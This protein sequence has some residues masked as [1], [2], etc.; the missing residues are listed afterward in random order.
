MLDPDRPYAYIAER[1]PLLGTQLGMQRDVSQKASSVGVSTIFLTASRCG[2]GCSMCDLHRNTLPTATPLGAI[3]RQIRFAQ[4]QLPAADWVKLYNSG[5]F[6]DRSSIPVADYRSIGELCG[7]YERVIIENH[8][9]F[10]RNRHVEFR[11]LIQGRLEIAVGLE[12]VQPRMLE[13]LGKQMTRDDFDRYAFFLRK[14][15]IDLRVFL[16]FGAPGLTVSESI[17]WTRLSVRHAVR[18]GARHVSLIPA[19]PGHGWN[20]MSDSLPKISLSDLADLFAFA[21]EDLDGTA[22]LSVDLWEIGNDRLTDTDQQRLKRFE[23]AIL[24][25]E[26]SRL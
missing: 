26:V 8:P 19:R 21:L 18:A 10:G 11:D 16:I 4:Q 2:V 12:S 6:F 23:Q 14:S 15:E 24:S 25:Q 5:N 9:K 1:E 22:C 13:R 17:R 7:H 3:P 20:R